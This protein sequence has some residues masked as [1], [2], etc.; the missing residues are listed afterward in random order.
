MRGMAAT[1]QE[2]TWNGRGLDHAA[3]GAS[4]P[5]S[6][7]HVGVD[8]AVAPSQRGGHQGQ[9]L[10]PRVR[11]PRRISE[12]SVVVGEF[13]QAQ[14][15]CEGDRKEQPGIGPQAVVVEGDLVWSG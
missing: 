10:V 6:A 2:S 3:Y 7:Q 13:T 1:P 9:Y 15:L 5:A 8:D 4:R 12:V 11:P 14:V